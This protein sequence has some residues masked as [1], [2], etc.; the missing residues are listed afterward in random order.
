MRS[1]DAGVMHIEEPYIPPFRH[2]SN[3]LLQRN[4]IKRGNSV[5]IEA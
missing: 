4:P 5:N 2:C 3:Q 1:P